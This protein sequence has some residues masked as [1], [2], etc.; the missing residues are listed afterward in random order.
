MQYMEFYQ[1]NI[2]VRRQKSRMDMKLEEEKS[3]EKNMQKEEKN[4]MMYKHQKHCQE[5]HMSV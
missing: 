1:M 2:K 4:Y 3:L 5:E